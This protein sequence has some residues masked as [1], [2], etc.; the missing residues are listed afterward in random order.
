MISHCD[1][2][3]RTAE[4]LAMIATYQPSTNQVPYF[5]EISEDFE[6]KK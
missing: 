6:L 1:K 4:E 2:S 3:L 5:D